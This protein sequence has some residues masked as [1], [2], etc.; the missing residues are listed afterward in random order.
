MQESNSDVKAFDSFRALNNEADLGERDQLFRDTARLFTF[1]WDR[2]DDRQVEQYDAV[3]CQLAE[4]VEVEGRSEVAQM[5][6]PLERAPGTVVVKLA[7]D[8]FEVAQPLLEFSNVLSDDDLIDIVSRASEE[9]RVAIAGRSSVAERVGDA[10]VTH[11]GQQSVIRLV[12]NEN[13]ELGQ[14][15]LS[16]L[17]KKASKDAG[18]A[19]NLRGRSGI[20]WKNLYDKISSAG[21]KVQ[22]KLFV[23]DKKA[24]P[25]TMD[26]VNAVVFNRMRNKAGF[27]SKEWR[28]AWNQ[29]KALADRRQLDQKSLARFARFG[30][31]HHFSAAMC[32]MLGLKQDVF[33]KWLASQDYLAISVGAKTLGMDPDVFAKGLSIL[34][35]RDFP[36]PDDITN[37][38]EKFKALETEEAEGIFELWRQH[39]FRR[40]S[41]SMRNKVAATG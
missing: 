25:G 21:E 20:D 4:L 41:P 2:C 34:P 14:D 40:K 30:Y 11:G 26:K 39:A 24:E 38:S 8:S 10:I 7:N 31:G 33:V 1:V 12:R 16:A 5:L 13:A 3:L 9:H 6:A 19:E 28:M 35:W 17:V 18:V 37:V 29:V 23:T 32:V 15:T 27:S 36:T 22:Q